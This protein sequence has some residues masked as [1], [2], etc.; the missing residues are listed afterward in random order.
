MSISV[1]VCSIASHNEVA[2][3]STSRVPQWR[4]RFVDRFGTDKEFRTTYTRSVSVALVLL[5]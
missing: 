4:I 1:A 3:G 2:L 5:E